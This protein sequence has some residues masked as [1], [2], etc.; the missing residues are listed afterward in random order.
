MHNRRYSES[1][2][3]EF[4]KPIDD[5]DKRFINGFRSIVREYHPYFYEQYSIECKYGGLYWDPTMIKRFSKAKRNTASIYYKIGDPMDS[6]EFLYSLNNVTSINIRG[7]IPHIPKGISKMTNLK[8]L[9]LCNVGNVDLSE[10]IDMNLDKLEFN[11]CNIES[12]D[13]LI[14]SLKQIS[15]KR[16]PIKEFPKVL[17]KGNLELASFSSPHFDAYYES[18]EDVRMRHMFKREIPKAGTN[19]RDV[20]GDV[21]FKIHIFQ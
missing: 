7:P 1:D 13:I 8:E 5:K 12:F 3:S 10:L 14:P 21:N 16:C 4:T 19:L 15:F 18:N 11:N 20:I 6:F 17:L 9:E 2:I